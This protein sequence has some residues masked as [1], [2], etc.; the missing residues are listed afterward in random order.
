MAAVPLKASKTQEK[1][2]LP[3][4]PIYALP[5]INLLLI[6]TRPLITL[7]PP[8]RHLVPPT[9]TPA[10]SAHRGSPPPSCAR[11]RGL[12]KAASGNYFAF[13]PCDMAMVPPGSSQRTREGDPSPRWVCGHFPTFHGTRSRPS[14]HL[15]PAHTSSR[16]C[17][18][19]PEWRRSAGLRRRGAGPGPGPM[20]PPNYIAQDNN[21]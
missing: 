2:I 5:D 17:P 7:G 16:R 12:E 10:P 15:V 14:R 19:T 3:S 21:W 20:E 18:A 13:F 6:M 11:L 4:M 9:R 1:A 8:L